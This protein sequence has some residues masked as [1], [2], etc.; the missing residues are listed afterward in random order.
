MHMTQSSNAAANRSERDLEAL[1][2]VGRGLRT[3]ADLDRHLGLILRLAGEAV[4]ANRASVMLLNR[5]TSRLEIRCSVGL[6]PEAILSTIGLG[7]GIAGW[8]AEHNQPFILHGAVTD[9]RFEGVDPTIDSSLC[10]PLAVEDRVLGVLNLTR[11]PGER[12]T[13]EDLRL[14]SSLADLASLAVEKAHLYATLR[15]REERVSGLLE[16]AINAQEAERRRIANEIHD[17]FL[18]ALTGLFLQTEIAKATLGHAGPAEAMAALDSVQDAI[19]HASE[20]LREVVFGAH[21]APVDELGLAPTLQ[22][23]VEESCSPC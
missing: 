19:L 16:A 10:L 2:S 12:F 18:Q 1:A 6:P 4:G 23:M 15:E 22:A 8:V 20:E 11:Q 3:S 5:E 17:G 14:A 13:V 7:E 21:A 9:S